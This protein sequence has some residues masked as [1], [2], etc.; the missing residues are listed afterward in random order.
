MVG[1]AGTRALVSRPAPLGYLE[2]AQVSS[3]ALFLFM[4]RAG[5]LEGNSS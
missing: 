2:H 3:V 5:Q 1:G 4:T